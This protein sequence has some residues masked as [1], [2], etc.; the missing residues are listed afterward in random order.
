MES[1]LVLD[2][3]E[4][5]LQQCRELLKSYKKRAAIKS[6]SYGYMESYYHRMNNVLNMLSII[7]SAIS[8]A[9]T[10]PMLTMDNAYV[11]AFGPQL[12][13]FS[14]M[15]LTTVLVGVSHMIDP[16]KKST[17]F[18]HQSCFYSDVCADIDEFL[19]RPQTTFDETTVF[20]RCISQT[21]RRLNFMAPFIPDKYISKATEEYEH[22]S[23]FEP[24]DQFHNISPASSIQEIPS[25]NGV[26][27]ALP[28][29]TNV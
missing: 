13:I 28:P 5:A 15:L 18:G 23:R 14:F 8:T 1:K 26:F 16:A 29:E 20:G 4:Q 3:N 12:I 2:S 6:K 27:I 25:D 7:T 22:E 24:L 11:S 21:I 9:A 19:T 10:S 17:N